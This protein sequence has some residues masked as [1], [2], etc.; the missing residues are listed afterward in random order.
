MPGEREESVFMCQWYQ[1]L[2]ALDDETYD[3]AFWRDTMGLISTVNEAIDT[4]EIEVVASENGSVVT[5]EDIAANPLWSGVDEAERIRNCITTYRDV[6]GISWVLLGGDTEVV[7]AYQEVAIDDAWGLVAFSL[8][9]VIVN[10]IVGDGGFAVLVGGLRAGMGLA[11]CASIPDLHATVHHALCIDPADELYA[12]ER[13]VPITDRGQ[14]IRPEVLAQHPSSSREALTARFRAARASRRW[15]CS[16]ASS[17]VP[18]EVST[19]A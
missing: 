18:G 16:I 19:W 7:A 2:F 13:P 14:P 5:L 10:Q 11:G 4:G 6:H 15:P 9:L 1:G 3:A 12:G 17:P 8:V